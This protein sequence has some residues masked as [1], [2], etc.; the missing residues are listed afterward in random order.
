MCKINKER[1]AQYINQVGPA[2]VTRK[3]IGDFILAASL[4][5]P[6]THTMDMIKELMPIVYDYLT[7]A[8]VRTTREF[9]TTTMITCAHAL[10]MIPDKPVLKELQ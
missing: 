1:V 8:E 9:L 4:I 2:E 3:I 5:P 6:D 10:N 7:P